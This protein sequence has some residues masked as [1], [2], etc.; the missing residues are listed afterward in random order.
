MVARAEDWRWSS[1]AGHL[2][3]EPPDYLREGIRLVRRAICRHPETARRLYRSL[4]EGEEEPVVPAVRAGPEEAG[5][6]ASTLESPRSM[7]ARS[8][9]SLHEA[10]LMIERRF[11]LPKGTLEGRRRNRVAKKARRAFCKLCVRG[12]GLEVAAVAAFLGRAPSTV[13]VL[14]RR[15]A[16]WTGSPG[17]RE[18]REPRAEREEVGHRAPSPGFRIRSTR[19]RLSPARETNAKGT[20]PPRGVSGGPSPGTG[21]RSRRR[22]GR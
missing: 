3:R 6:P 9:A 2:R 4:V 17:I 1:H 19:P 18:N 11:H 5:P 20:S 7:A 16:P 13:S 22:D 15:K 8:K 12:L 10:A 14:S 21:G